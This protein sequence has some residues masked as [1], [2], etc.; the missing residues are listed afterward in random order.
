[1]YTFLEEFH[2]WLLLEGY[3]G[4]R[5]NTEVKCDLKNYFYSKY[6]TTIKNLSVKEMTLV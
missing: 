4:K 2:M 3:E 5:K 1:M 6:V